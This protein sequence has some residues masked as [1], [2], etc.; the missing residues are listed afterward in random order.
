VAQRTLLERRQNLWRFGRDLGKASSVVEEWLAA[1]PD[2]PLA[3]D[4]RGEIAFLRASYAEAASAFRRAVE[5]YRSR[6]QVEGLDRVH[7]AEQRPTRYDLS[8]ALLKL[9]LS[10]SRGRLEGAGPTLRAAVAL[11]DELAVVGLTGDADDHLIQTRYHALSALGDLSLAAGQYADAAEWYGQAIALS[12][13]VDKLT[14]GGSSLLTGS[15]EHNRALA[16]LRD[17]RPLQAVE[18]ARA[19]VARDPASPVYQE[20]LASALR[21]SD[22][23]EEAVDGYR[24]ALASDPTL[25]PASNNLGVTLARLGRTDEALA[26]FRQAIGAQ[27]SYPL[28]WWN[29]GVAL[30]DT[31]PLASMLQAQGALGRAAAL[32]HDLRGDPPEFR[33]DES[34]YASNLDVSRPLPA[35]WAFAAGGSPGVGGTGLLLVLALLWR[36]GSGLGLDHAVGRLAERLLPE[37]RRTL[38]PGWWLSRVPAAVAV[39]ASLIIVAGISALEAG[40]RSP[41]AAAAETA[42]LTAGAAAGLTL[43][44]GLRRLAG[45]PA[46]D[47]ARH[48]GWPPAVGLGAALALLHIPLLPVP[49]LAEDEPTGTSVRWRG[50]LGVAALALALTVAAIVVGTPLT[51]GLAL[52]CIALTSSTL[53]PVKPLDGGYLTRPRTA[54]AVTAIFALATVAVTLKWV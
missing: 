47:G 50:V 8:R 26:A 39:G 43:L 22:R 41:L 51:R 2:D 1:A 36:V 54:W 44:V 49:C 20:V 21:D 35:D 40:W 5:L 29:L 6:A 33:L 10:Q 28:G 48:F 45:V 11:T 23:A 34:V 37:R 19:A 7:G 30:R 13:L 12:S 53:L 14:P 16:L 4:R 25:Y 38:P 18:S 27:P 42:L 15:V 3:H 52:G 9:G 17:G 46:E 31:H 24:S 32:D